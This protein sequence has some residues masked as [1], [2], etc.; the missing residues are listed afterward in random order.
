MTGQIT[1]TWL[2]ASRIPRDLI[3][4]LPDASEIEVI[5]DEFAGAV[6]TMT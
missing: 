3:E 2:G 5:A 4:L 6:A 1:G